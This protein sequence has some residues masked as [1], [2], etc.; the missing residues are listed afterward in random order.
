MDR[1]EITAMILL[2]L[3][4]AYDSISH[5]LLVAKLESI[6]VSGI[7]REWFISYLKDRKQHVRIESHLSE[8]PPVNYGVPQGSILS[9]LLFLISISAT[10]NASTKSYVDETKLY[11]SFPLKELNEG[12]VRL[13]A[14]LNKLGNGVV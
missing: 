3:S 12:L 6:G 13:K 4:K 1:K 9:P 7:T 14:D 8:P 11:L 10:T 2:H 5:S